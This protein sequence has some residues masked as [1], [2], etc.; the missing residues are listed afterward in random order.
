MNRINEET[1]GA[2]TVSDDVLAAVV[3]DAVTEIP[4]VISM[5]DILTRGE[6]LSKKASCLILSPQS[7]LMD[8]R[9]FLCKNGYHITRE[10][11]VFEDGKTVVL[12][13]YINVAFGTKIPQLAWRLQKHV[14][15]RIRSVT[16]ITA[17]EINIHVQGVEYE[18][19]QSEKTESVSN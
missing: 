10:E 3:A 13:L 2:V 18:E 7:H 9:A 17:K 8:F 15:N 5:E 11:T 16:G 12:D 14:A 19:N 1:P 6:A 4:G